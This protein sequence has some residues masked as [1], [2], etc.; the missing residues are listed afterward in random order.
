VFWVCGFLKFQFYRHK[1]L[2]AK[3]WTTVLIII[4]LDD[5]LYNASDRGWPFIFQLQE[6]CYNI[7]AKLFL[8]SQCTERHTN[9]SSDHLWCISEIDF[10]FSATV[11]ADWSFSVTFWRIQW[12]SPP[13]QI[14]LKFSDPPQFVRSSVTVF[15]SKFVLYSR[16]YLL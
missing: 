8:L 5:C 12:F 3:T 9:L 6:E 4:K 14:N 16:R 2:I 11:R 15:F 13:S 1:A 7:S 10:T